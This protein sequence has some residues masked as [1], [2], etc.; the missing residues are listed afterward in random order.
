MNDNNN[1]EQQETVYEDT[2]IT[3]KA[4]EIALIV[5]QEDAADGNGMY[6]HSALHTNT[7]DNVLPNVGVTLMHILRTKP[8]IMADMFQEV[9]DAVNADVI[10]IENEDGG[11]TL[12]GVEIAGNA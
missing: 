9:V 7:G 8:G 11:S 12:A 2:E 6:F 10:E 5:S 1:P 3:V 4:G